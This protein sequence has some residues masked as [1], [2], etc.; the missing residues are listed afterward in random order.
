MTNNASATRAQS[1]FIS[2]TKD[3]ER[4][5]RELQKALASAGYRTETMSDIHPGDR[6]IASIYDALNAADV[7]VIL[8]SRAA[9]NSAGVV[10]EIAASVAAVE[11]SSDKRII[12]V[13]LDRGL[14]P[15]G[16]LASYQWIFTSGDPAEVSA[17]VLKAIE[18]GGVVDRARE[19]EIARQSNKEN[20]AI[21]NQLANTASVSSANWSTGIRIVSIVGLVLTIGLITVLLVATHS[22]PTS[23]IVSI[24]GSFIGLGAGILGYSFGRVSGRSGD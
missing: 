3:D 11:R 1:V 8:L 7:V 22:V 17:D 10:Y 9:L 4:A 2:Y 13:A 6:W 23:L 15:S 5:A 18:R 19:R 24:I 12:P 16:L 21:L 14:S 20:I